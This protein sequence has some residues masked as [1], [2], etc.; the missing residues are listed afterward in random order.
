MRDWWKLAA[1]DGRRVNAIDVEQNRR[2][3]SVAIPDA[4]TLLV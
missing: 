1:S 4:A 2:R 3:E